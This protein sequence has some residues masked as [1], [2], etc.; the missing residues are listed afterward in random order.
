MRVPRTVFVLAFALRMW[1]ADRLRSLER[2]LFTPRM[3]EGGRRAQT[4]AKSVIAAGS[5]TVASGGIVALVRQDLIGGWLYAIALQGVR[6]IQS[7]G[8]I[9]EVI[10]A[11]WSSIASLV[12]S[13]IPNEILDAGVEA[14]ATAIRTE[15]GI[16][17]FVIAV[18]A[19]GTGIALFMWFLVNIDFNPIGIFTGRG[20]D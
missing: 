9:G 8:S 2:L 18:L 12:S 19:T 20:G 5:A 14:S 17:G 10:S 16:A 4:E 7:L 13:G 3:R 1:F 15:W 11:F 6:T